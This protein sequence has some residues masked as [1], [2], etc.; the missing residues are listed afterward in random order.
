MAGVWLGYEKDKPLATGETGG[1]AAAPI[2]VEYMNYALSQLPKEDFAVPEGIV[3]AYVD[4]NTGKL[5]T[6][7]SPNRV[8]VAFKAGTVPNREGSNLPRIGEPGSRVTT[9]VSPTSDSPE[10]A[11]KES[12]EESETS[13][14]LRQGY[15]DE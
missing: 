2:W 5:A 15:Q 6:T 8:R 12:E 11:H 13:D 7:S 14:F 10:S 3:F 9:T 1:R 4:R